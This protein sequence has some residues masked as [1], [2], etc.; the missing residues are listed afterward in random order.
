MCHKE[1][2]D[3]L[4][5]KWK[6]ELE[7]L[8]ARVEAALAAPEAKKVDATV[9][10]HARAALEA[11]KRDGSNGA[12]NFELSKSLLEEALKSLANT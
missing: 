11:V 2:Y 9:L 6:S 8:T 10:E 4:S 5:L 1:G 12:H 3:E 7:S